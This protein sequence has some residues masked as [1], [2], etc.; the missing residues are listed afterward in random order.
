M[1][2]WG[3][4]FSEEPDSEF[5][6]I[7]SSI[8]FDSRLWEEELLQNAAYAY[9]LERAGIL[10]TDELEAITAGLKELFEQGSFW[11]DDDEDIHSAVERALAERIGEAAFKLHTGRSR[12]EQIATDMRMF[13]K[14]K[15]VEI[16]ALINEAEK[17]IYRAASQNI[18]TLLPGFTHLQH[19]QPVRLA[20]HLLAWFFMLKRDFDRMVS[21][22]KKMDFCP[23][24]AGALSGN[25]FGIDRQY[26]AELL[27]F[28][29]P[30]DNAMDAVSD[31]DF[32]LH[33]VSQLS[34]LAVHLSR[35]AEEVVIW[36]TPEF[37][38]IELSDAYSTGSSLMPN[39][40]NP[41]SAEL[42]RG[43]SA[44][45]IGCWVQ[46]AALLK[47]LPL[48]YNRDLQEDKPLVF[49]AADTAIS[50]LK[51]F[52][53][54]VDTAKFN[55]EKMSEKLNDELLLAT[56]IADYLVAK[57]IAFRK[58]HEITGKIVAHAQQQKKKLSG[59]SLDELRQF[60]DVFDDG[61]YDLFS[62]EK[63]IERRTALGGTSRKAV[64]EQLAAAEKLIKRQAE[65]I[66]EKS[67][68]LESVRDL[69]RR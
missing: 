26:L 11:K 2:L 14:K 28:K 49:D 46:L 45:I 33:F 34:N 29:A 23:L 13:L 39:K 10:S 9:G 52:N 32:V 54:M 47:G 43:M 19:A 65:W 57:G 69:L 48:A 66:E 24:G 67:A 55:S 6:R 18:D 8:A 16:N 61:Y 5:M 63:A 56:E 36:S 12:N 37:G 20:F 31:R 3:G 42:I 7:S 62:V 44:R 59:L 40:K 60:S 53:G 41:D 25:A 38:F 17:V 50:M 22:Y 51:M 58:A 21:C 15:I 30:A 35:F 64:E 4:R 68:H 27:G 1:K